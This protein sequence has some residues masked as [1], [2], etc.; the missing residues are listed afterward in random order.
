MDVTSRKWP[1]QEYLLCRGLHNGFCL[2]LKT[3]LCT[4]FKRCHFKVRNTWQNL[5][6]AVKSEVIYTACPQFL[7][8][9]VAQ[10]THIC[11]RAHMHAHICTHPHI[12]TFTHTHAHTLIFNIYLSVR[13]RF[14]S[15]KLFFFREF[16]S[17]FISKPL[18][19]DLRRWL[20]VGE[21]LPLLLHL[22]EHWLFSISGTR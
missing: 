22:V 20:S 8:Y 19:T 5:G 11:A 7:K 10:N 14:F 1:K 12:H 4:P 21:L 16:D 17:K 15:E 13:L 9:S 6:Q 2:L 3:F 18:L